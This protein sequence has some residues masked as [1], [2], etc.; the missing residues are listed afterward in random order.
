[1]RRGMN[2][3]ALQAGIHMPAIFTSFAVRA[4]IW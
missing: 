3:L 1:M 4:E 2:G